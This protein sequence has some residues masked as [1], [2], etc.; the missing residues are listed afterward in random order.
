MEMKRR[1]GVGGNTNPHPVSPKSDMTR[2]ICFTMFNE[3][4]KEWDDDIRYVIYQKEKCPTTG[5]EHFQGYIEVSKPHR[6]RWF[7][8]VLND[9]AAH[10]EKR[11]GTRDQARD[12]C[13]KDDTRI[14]EPI[15]YGKWIS[16]AGHR[17]D[18][19]AVSDMIKDGASIKEVAEEVPSTFIK[20]S[21]GIK[22]LKSIFDNNKRMR[23]QEVICLIGQAG[24]GKTRYVY[25]HENIDDVYKLDHDNNNVWFD[26]YEGE[27]ILLIDDFYGWIR[28]GWLLNILDRYPLRLPVK[29]GHTYANWDKVY[30]TSNKPPKD[31]YEVGFTDALERRL[32]KIILLKDDPAERGERKVER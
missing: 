19:D 2:S 12:Y 32:N 18:L 17:S 5:R 16:G 22:A 29:G 15:E 23:P 3:P 14:S 27:H 1:N 4:P 6:F 9:Q 7:K 13:R 20:Y 30:I 26:G 28:Y 8:D 21:K 10:L 11:R 24:T 31:W 25:D